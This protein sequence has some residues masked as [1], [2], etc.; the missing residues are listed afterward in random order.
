[1]HAWRPTDC[2]ESS[3]RPMWKVA[4]DICKRK[5]KIILAW[6]KFNK[7]LVQDHPATFLVYNFTK[8]NNY[9]KFGN[10]YSKF[11]DMIMS[12]NLDRTLCAFWVVG[13]F[14][15]KHDMQSA[16]YEDQKLNWT[17]LGLLLASTTLKELYKVFWKMPEIKAFLTT[18][19]MWWCFVTK[20]VLTYCEK[21]RSKVLRS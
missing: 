18:I 11:I 19:N 1:M 8:F 7:I 6:N 16:F 15:C 2:W 9:C 21:T 3:S 13:L 14:Q 5:D 10:K 20:I 12:M 4:T 17:V